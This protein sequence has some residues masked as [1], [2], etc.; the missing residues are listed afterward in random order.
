[1]RGLLGRSQARSSTC[2]G[3]QSTVVVS[4]YD[5]QAIRIEAMIDPISQGQVGVAP[6][7][8]RAVLRRVCGIH[9]D[10]LPAS[11][12]CLASDT[13]QELAPR[14]ITDALAEF[15]VLDHAHNRQILNGNQI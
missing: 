8:T 12:C 6:A 11:P 4:V 9:S 1:M 5:Q 15:A 10:I 2:K 14:H 3:I 13:R 7:T